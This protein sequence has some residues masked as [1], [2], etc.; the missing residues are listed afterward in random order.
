MCVFVNVKRYIFLISL[1]LYLYLSFSHTYTHALA[2]ILFLSFSLARSVLSI[3]ISFFFFYLRF[4]LVSFIK[5]YCRA[6]KGR[7]KACSQR[8][9]GAL[10]SYTSC[11]G[12]HLYWSH[13]RR[14]IRLKIA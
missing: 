13:D 4:V 6:Y 8:T 9:S 10:F 12:T 14:R 7:P 11:A 3:C 1:I 5:C 2:L